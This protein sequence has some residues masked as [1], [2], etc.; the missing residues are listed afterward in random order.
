MEKHNIELQ[1]KDIAHIV[2]T[3]RDPRKQVIRDIKKILSRRDRPTAFFA[4]TDLIA[5]D[6]YSAAGEAGLRIPEDLS[7]IGYADLNFAPYIV[8]PLTTVRQNGLKMGQEAANLILDRLDRTPERSPV[9]KVI[10]TEL[11]IRKSTTNPG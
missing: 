10:P 7:V 2:H 8:P 9:R 1:D 6:V 4:P 5:L 3:H 11:V